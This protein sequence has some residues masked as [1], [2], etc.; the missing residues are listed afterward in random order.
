MRQ[1]LYD[2]THKW[3]INKTMDEENRLVVTQRGRGSE[4][5]ERGRGAHMYGDI[6]TRLL[7]VSMMQSIQKFI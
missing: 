2:F 7:V 1:I 5:G 4:V 6:K 3:K